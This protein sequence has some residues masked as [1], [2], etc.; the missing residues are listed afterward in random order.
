MYL[1][2]SY[3]LFIHNK[4][5]CFFIMVFVMALYTVGTYVLLL[6]YQC[7]IV[8]WIYSPL[9]RAAMMGDKTHQ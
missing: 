1:R 6:N 5:A 8:L 2:N 7:C 3:E 4:I 9:G